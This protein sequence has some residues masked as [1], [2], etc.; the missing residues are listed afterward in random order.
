MFEY[1]FSIILFYYIWWVAI[2]MIGKNNIITKI[3]NLYL[4]LLLLLFYN[5]QVLL[6]LKK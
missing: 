1:N 6:K 3:R 5:L 4:L 2:N